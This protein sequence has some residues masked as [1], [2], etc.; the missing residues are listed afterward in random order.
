VK[1][2]HLAVL[3]LAALSCIALAALIAAPDLFGF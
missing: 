1:P 3:A 2:A